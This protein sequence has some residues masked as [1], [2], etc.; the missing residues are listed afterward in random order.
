M[1][2]CVCWSFSLISGA[3]LV[4][5]VVVWLWW[6][7]GKGFMLCLTSSLGPSGYAVS[8]SLLCVNCSPENWR[9]MLKPGLDCSVANCWPAVI[10]PLPPP[11]HPQR[12]EQLCPL[13][14]SGGRLLPL[15]MRSAVKGCVEMIHAT[16]TGLSLVPSQCVGLIFRLTPSSL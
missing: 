8:S 13:P 16:I 12:R 7:R 5:L 4:N 1:S 2:L 15:Q 3:F 14:I 10:H 9:W 11:P 6:G